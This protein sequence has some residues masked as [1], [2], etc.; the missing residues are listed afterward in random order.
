MAPRN[1]TIQLDEALIREARV[2][3][4]KEGMSLSGMVARDLRDKLVA[5]RLYEQAREFALDDMEETA[6]SA[7]KVKAWTREELHDRWDSRHR[8][9]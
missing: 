9:G 2:V 5:D 7:S 4:A 1:V 8:Q 6:K 3:A